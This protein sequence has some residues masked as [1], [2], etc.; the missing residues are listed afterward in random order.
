MLN[1][2]VFENQWKQ[3]RNELRPRWKALTDADVKT[4]DGHVDVLVELLQEKYGYAQSQAEEEVNRFLIE[5]VGM[6]AVNPSSQ[7]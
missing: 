3:L 7:G 2:D 1:A 5:T 4:I 6:E